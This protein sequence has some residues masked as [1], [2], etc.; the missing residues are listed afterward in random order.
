MLLLIRFVVLCAAKIQTYFYTTKQKQ[1]IFCFYIKIV[2]FSLLYI[3]CNTRT[4]TNTRPSLFLFLFLA[5]LFFFP[6]LSF[7]SLVLPLLLIRADHLAN[8]SGTEQ[9][10]H[11]RRPPR[12]R[13]GIHS[14]HRH[15]SRPP[16]D[17]PTSNSTRPPR[18][19]RFRAG[20]WAHPRPSGMPHSL[21]LAPSVSSRAPSPVMPWAYCPI[22]S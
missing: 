20:R 5:V 3:R 13:S 19:D 7:P 10:H 18:L 2:C 16:Q 22:K 12:H 4:Q 21:S 15:E 14:S 17:P 8:T 9:Q 11:R 1:R 6:F